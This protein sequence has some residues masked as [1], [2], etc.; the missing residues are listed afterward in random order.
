MKATTFEANPLLKEEDFAKAKQDDPIDYQCRHLCI[1]PESKF[2]FFAPYFDKIGECINPLLA[3]RVKFKPSLVSRELTVLHSDD[4]RKVVHQF[5]GVEI[6]E[7]KG[8]KRIRVIAADTSKSSDSFIIGCG[9]AEF[10]EQ[11]EGKP[12][13]VTIRKN[14]AGHDTVEE[15]PLTGKVVFDTIVAWRPDSKHPV[16]YLNV[17]SVLMQLLTAFPNV[18]GV[19]FD[20]YNSESLRQKVLVKGIECVTHFLSNPQQVRIY[21]VLRGLIWNNMAEYLPA[22][23]Y[24]TLQKDATVDDELRQLLF[25]NKT[26]VDHPAS[27]SKDLSDVFAL[28]AYH[29]LLTEYTPKPRFDAMPDDMKSLDEYVRL[30]YA[31]KNNLKNELRRDPTNEEIAKH[32]DLS[33]DWLLEI[34][35]YAQDAYYQ[36]KTL[37]NVL[38]EGTI[39]E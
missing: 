14:I 24:R 35:D 33:L 2:G 22:E 20:T 1:V 4:G 38:P 23:E 27:G 5:T 25:E 21:T 32:L 34:I 11:E 39:T 31:A 3:N 37:G 19:H 15:I 10:M 17:E 30:Y 6:L 13:S 36:D 28:L 26:K 7:I 12:K 16:D 8:D 18:V 9:Y 29:A